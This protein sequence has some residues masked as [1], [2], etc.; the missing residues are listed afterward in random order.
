MACWGRIEGL[1]VLEEPASQ[2][3]PLSLHATAPVK[4]NFCW[5]GGFDALQPGRDQSMARTL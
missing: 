5:H 3:D 2:V 1:L 4:L